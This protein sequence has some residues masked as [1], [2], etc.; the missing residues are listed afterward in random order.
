M[1]NDHQDALAAGLAVSEYAPN[2]KSADEIRAL[3]QWV[4]TRLNADVNVDAELSCETAEFPLLLLPQALETSPVT[5]EL[6]AGL[7]WWDA[8]L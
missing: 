5:T 3:W 2:G 8:G 4:A 7:A 6:F 1:R